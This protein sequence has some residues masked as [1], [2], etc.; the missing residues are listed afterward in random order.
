[1]QEDSA[2][3][4]A[5]R[6]RMFCLTRRAHAVMIVSVVVMLVL[7][8]MVIT[9]F[10]LVRRCMGRMRNTVVMGETVAFICNVRVIDWR[11]D[12]IRQTLVTH[13]SCLLAKH[14]GR[15]PLHHR[16]MWYS[17]GRLKLS[18]RDDSP[19]EARTCWRGDF[20]ASLC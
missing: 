15:S 12:S 17:A 20:S 11:S 2:H 16:E 9:A 1:M 3:I 5:M 8:M 6:M 19:H 4:M 7:V 10:A 13:A 18:A 14:A